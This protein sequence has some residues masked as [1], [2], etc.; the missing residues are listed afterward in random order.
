MD[1]FYRKENIEVFKKWV[2]FQVL[3]DPR[4]TLEEYDERTYKIFYQQKVARKMRNYCFI[5]IINFLIFILLK[6]Y[7]IE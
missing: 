7:F 4:L 6:T 1:D 2:Y 3:N 5:Y